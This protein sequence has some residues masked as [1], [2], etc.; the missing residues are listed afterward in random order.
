MNPAAVIT[1]YYTDSWEVFLLILIFG[2]L[3]IY[4]MSGNNQA[5]QEIASVIQ[6]ELTSV[7]RDCERNIRNQ[8]LKAAHEFKNK[9]IN[10][11]KTIKRKRDDEFKRFKKND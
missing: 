7:Q 9:L 8:N 4:K 1:G 10:N 3:I 6:M 5:A 11:F 2:Y